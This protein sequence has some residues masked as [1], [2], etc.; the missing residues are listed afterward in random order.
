[1]FNDE[2][3][4]TLTVVSFLIG[5]ANYRENLTQSDKDDLLKKLDTQT[6]E[7]LETIQKEIKTQNEMLR[8]I[9]GKLDCERKE[10]LT[11]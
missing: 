6:K 11:F 4:D 8:E 1:M 3:L 10:T 9:L 7:I 2:M 5:V